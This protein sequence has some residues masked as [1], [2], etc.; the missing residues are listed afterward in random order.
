MFSLFVFHS[1]ALVC[2]RCSDIFFCQFSGEKKKPE[3]KMSYK[4]NSLLFLF[5][6]NLHPIIFILCTIVDNLEKQMT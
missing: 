6:S 4:K 3:Q 5:L 1:A 2:R